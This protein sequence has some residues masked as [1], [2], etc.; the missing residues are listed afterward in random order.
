MGGGDVVIIEKYWSKMSF[1]VSIS[2]YPPFYFNA[3]RQLCRS[4]GRAPMGPP[5]PPKGASTD[6]VGGMRE[7]D[8]AVVRS[9]RR[10]R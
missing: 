10:S 4:L 9:S 3:V 6:R 5:R 2:S 8:H 7:I 1:Q